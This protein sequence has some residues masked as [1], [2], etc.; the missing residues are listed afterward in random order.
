MAGARDAMQ[1]TPSSPRDRVYT[2]P[3]L[4]AVFACRELLGTQWSCKS[5]IKMA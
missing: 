4:K 2:G 3:P 1:L 5:G